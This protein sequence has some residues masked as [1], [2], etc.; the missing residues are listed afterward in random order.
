M[1]GSKAQKPPNFNELALSDALNLLRHWLKI[2]FFFAKAITDEPISRD[3]EQAF[4]ETKSDI[5]KIQRVLGPKL[6][7]GISF[8][9]EKMRDMLR[10]SISIDH[11][12]TLPAADRRGLLS[13]WHYVFIYLGQAVG[14]LQFIVEGYVPP[15]RTGRRRG[16]SIDELKKTA[17]GSKSSKVGNIANPKFWVSII[18][19]AG[20]AWFLWKQLSKSM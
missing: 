5:T 4:L 3:D 1:A 18:L 14:A 12:R 9:V 16:A 20:A 2:K 17:A 10:Q 8:G 7:E 6:P 11:L 13:M 15:P 19:I